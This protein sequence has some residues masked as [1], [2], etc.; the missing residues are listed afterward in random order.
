MW[1]LEGCFHPP[2]WQMHRHFEAE[3]AVVEKPKEEVKGDLEKENAPW[4]WRGRR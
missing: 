2:V 4:L 1:K 3:T